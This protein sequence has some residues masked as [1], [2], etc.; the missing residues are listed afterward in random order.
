[1]RAGLYALSE[2]INKEH[3]EIPDQITFSIET[4]RRV[5]FIFLV[6]IFRN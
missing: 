5:Q 2:R 1:M 4:G 6:I 3:N